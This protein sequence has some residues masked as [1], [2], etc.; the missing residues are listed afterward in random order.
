VGLADEFEWL[1]G[2][3]GE[4]VFDEAVFEADAEIAEEQLD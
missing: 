3:G 2:S 4:G 1:A